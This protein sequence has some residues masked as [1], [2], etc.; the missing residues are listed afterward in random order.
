MRCFFLEFLYLKLVFNFGLNPFQNS[1]WVKQQH[2]FETTQYT[3]IPR[4]F[5]SFICESPS[6]HTQFPIVIH[7]LLLSFFHINIA[8]VH[9]NNFHHT[10]PPRARYSMFIFSINIL[11]KRFSI[12]CQYCVHIYHVTHQNNR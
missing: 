6:V 1:Y 11:V 7:C 8:A 10:P 4:T 3:S 2:S 9:M 12:S 5:I